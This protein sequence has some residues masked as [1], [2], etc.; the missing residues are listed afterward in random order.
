MDFLRNRKW[1]TKGFSFW[2]KQKKNVKVRVDTKNCLIVTKNCLIV[3][4]NCLIV[5]KNCLIVIRRISRNRPMNS[6]VYKSRRNQI[7]VIIRL[8]KLKLIT[9]QRKERILLHQCANDNTVGERRKMKRR[10]EMLDH[11]KEENWKEY[12]N[13]WWKRGI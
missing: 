4:K 10:R 2:V 11:W 1:G 8:V 5:T 6:L 3:T 12:S 9:L 7:Y 13:P